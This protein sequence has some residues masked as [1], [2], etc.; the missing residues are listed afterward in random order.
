MYFHKFFVVFVMTLLCKLRDKFKWFM[1]D[2]RG[3]CNV[4]EFAFAFWGSRA[5]L[6]VFWWSSTG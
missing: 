5:R 4:S 2:Y 1:C 3:N 6:L